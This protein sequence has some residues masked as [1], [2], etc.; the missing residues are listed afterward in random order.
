VKKRAYIVWTLTLMLLLGLNAVAQSADAV[1]VI[2]KIYKV[3]VA[4][5]A[6]K[7]IEV[8]GKQVKPGDVLEYQVVY[9]NQSKDLVQNLK[10][11][12]P[13][14]SGFIYLAATAHPAKVDASLDGKI[15]SP[16]PLKK[17]STRNG[18]T[19]EEVVALSLYRALRWDIGDLKP[20]ASVTVRARVKVR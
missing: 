3:E 1:S 6:E 9:H 13:I 8:N 4:A 7:L 12:L 15:F 19:T 10:A 17:V 14:P 2:Q 18:V 5:G 16:A 11:D 20:G